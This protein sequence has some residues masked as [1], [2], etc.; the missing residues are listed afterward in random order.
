MTF[1][2]KIL[3]ILIMIFAMMFLAFSVV[4][5]STEKNWSEAAKKVK[6]DLDKEKGKVSTAQVEL[7]AAKKALDAAKVES[8]QQIKLL[9]SQIASLQG[10]IK[11]AQTEVTQTRDTTA[12]ATQTLQSAMR[13]AEARKAETDVLRKQLSEVQQQAN[14]FKITQTELNDQI[15]LLQRQLETA[16]RNNADLRDRTGAFQ[17]ELRRNG[18]SDDFTQLRGVNS[19]APDVEG[20]VIRTDARGQRV[21]ISIGSDSGLVVGHELDVW[22]TTPTAEYVARIRIEAVDPDQAVGS[23]IGKTVQGKKIQ[24]GDIVSPKIRPRS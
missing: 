22:R 5:F 24:E 17:A 13:E 20:H 10:N 1:V 9:Q 8:D 18:L 14:E 7:E 21:E 4:V 6:T 2:G 11:D 15:R 19:V 16:Q 23:V 3:V 12:T